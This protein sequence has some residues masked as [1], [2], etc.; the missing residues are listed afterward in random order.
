[1]QKEIITQGLAKHTG[2]TKLRGKCFRFNQELVTMANKIINMI[3]HSSLLNNMIIHIT[4]RQDM[5]MNNP[6]VS[7][8]ESDTA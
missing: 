3:I 2:M 7:Q 8:Q 5:A 6:Y 1:M 4:K